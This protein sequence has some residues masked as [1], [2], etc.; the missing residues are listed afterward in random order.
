[1][2]ETLS[3]VGTAVHRGFTC[4]GRSPDLVAVHHQVVR[5]SERLEDDHPAG[6]GG[7][8]KQ[9]VSQLRDV[10]IHLVCAL[11]QVC[12]GKQQKEDVGHP[13]YMS[14]LQFLPVILSF[15]FSV[16]CKFKNRFLQ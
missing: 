7:S 15:L 14:A 10:H 1:M 16:L 8:F 4:S 5:R 2:A 3:V 13:G 11:D 12:G 9:H 6:V